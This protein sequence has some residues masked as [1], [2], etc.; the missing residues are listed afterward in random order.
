VGRPAFNGPPAEQQD[1]V[2]PISKFS[3]HFE[4]VS[5]ANSPLKHSRSSV[6]N[7]ILIPVSDYYVE[8]E[9]SAN[10]LKAFANGR[11]IVIPDM[12]NRRKSSNKTG[13]KGLKSFKKLDTGMEEIAESIISDI[14]NDE[15]K[16]E[17]NE[18]QQHNR[19]QRAPPA[20]SESRAISNSS[21]QNIKS[22]V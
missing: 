13:N 11:A 6:N 22:F 19:L 20:H 21:Q 9:R 7:T 1:M 17:V 3:S 16:R 5:T 15:E 2:I 14:E 10:D 18:S 4:Y 12:K 8:V